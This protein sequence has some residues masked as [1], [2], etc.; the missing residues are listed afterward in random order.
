MTASLRLTPAAEVD[1]A[2]AFSW[3]E[4]QRLGLGIRFINAADL[5]VTRIRESPSLFPE[6][7]A[8]FRR[9]LLHRFPYGIYFSLESGAVVVHAVLHLHRDPA[10]AR[11]RLSG[12]SG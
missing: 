11:R 2:A 4:Q 6:V 7:V 5:V 10:V 12:G 3:Y 9:G 1:L 8:G